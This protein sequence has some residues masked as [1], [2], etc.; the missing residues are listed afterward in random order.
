[1]PSAAKPC[2]RTTAGLSAAGALSVVFPAA[3]SGVISR[4]VDLS[5]GILS[6]GTQKVSSVPAP[7]TSTVCC[8]SPASLIRK[9]SN[10][11]CASTRFT[12]L[13]DCWSYYSSEA[14]W[15]RVQCRYESSIFGL[16]AHN[17]CPM[18]EL[19]MGGDLI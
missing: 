19:S 7:S 17:S 15:L 4:T 12:I 16:C 6:L 8:R 10:G 1:M 14:S 11:F 9:C 3:A 2:T 5:L 18:E 13:V